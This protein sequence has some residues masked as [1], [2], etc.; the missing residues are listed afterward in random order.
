MSKQIFEQ[1]SLSVTEQ[2]ALLQQ[3]N[4]VINDHQLA[5]HFLKTIGYYRLKS[6]FKPFLSSSNN[7]SIGFLPGITFSNILNLYTFDRELRLL[8]VD[9]IERIEVALRVAVS[10][11]M[12]EQHHPHW[13]LD[14]NLFANAKFHEHFLREVASHLGRSN[15]D[16][17]RNYYSNYRSPEHPPSWMV[18]ECLSFGTVSKAYA[19][20]KDRS[21]RKEVGDVFGQYSEVLKSWLRALTYTRNVC[22]HHG[23]L[24][25]RFFINKPQKAAIGYLPEQN[26]SPFLLQAYIIIKLLN[27]I[28]PSNHWKERLSLLFEEHELLVPFDQMGFGEPWSTDPFWEI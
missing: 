4:L 22:A 19:N 26:S 11:A 24:W 10:N 27:V 9:A 5:E 3:R 6:Y 16:F 14:Q 2:L 21:V 7:S 8:I 20:I 12:C 18:M 28:A 13:Y 17:I 1:P 25:N 15:E 23:R